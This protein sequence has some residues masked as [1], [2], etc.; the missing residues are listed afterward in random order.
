MDPHRPQVDE[1]EILLFIL[2]LIF[3]LLVMVF[4]IPYIF[5]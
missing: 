4:A 1:G 2:T 3:A 5:G